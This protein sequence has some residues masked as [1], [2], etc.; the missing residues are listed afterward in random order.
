VEMEPMLFALG[1]EVAS[2]R[3]DPHASPGS[4]FR[5]QWCDEWNF[6]RADKAIGR[7]GSDQIDVVFGNGTCI[8]AFMENKLHRREAE[9]DARGT[10]NEL[11]VKGR[12]PE[13]QFALYGWHSSCTRTGCT[14]NL[15]DSQHRGG[16]GI[17]TLP[18]N[19]KEEICFGDLTDSDCET[20]AKIAQPVMLKRADPQSWLDA[21]A[22][23]GNPYRP[24]FDPIEI[25]QRFFK[26]LWDELKYSIPYEATK[27]TS[28]EGHGR[29]TPT[30]AHLPYDNEVGIGVEIH[31]DV[32]EIYVCGYLGRKR[33]KPTPEHKRPKIDEVTDDEAMRDFVRTELRRLEIS[34]QSGLRHHA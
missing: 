32:E 2:V 27:L 13:L 15:I 33:N 19:S 26:I 8:V 3:S 10:L 22:A 18:D 6:E 31:C 9:R 7:A 12:L 14:H 11:K 23:Y 4:K 17:I 16:I 21:P 1:W 25:Q 20:L 28:S 29:A 24:R 30:R 5:H 34:I